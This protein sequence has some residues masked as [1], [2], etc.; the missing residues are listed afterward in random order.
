MIKHSR[1]LLAALAPLL[2][3]TACS[4]GGGTTPLSTVAS[5]AS[6][7]S[8]AMQQPFGLPNAAVSNAAGSKVSRIF[9]AQFQA[10][11]IELFGANG[12]LLGNSGSP[13][14]DGPQNIVFDKTGT[15]FVAA[16]GTDD[17]LSY[18]KALA[19]NSAVVHLT[20]S[21]VGL[22][23]G[24]TGT[25]F[26]TLYPSGDVVAY[27][28]NGQQVSPTIPGSGNV[29]YVAVDAKGKIYVT[30]SA[31]NTLKTYKPDGTP[32]TPTIKT[33]LNG[34]GPVVVDAAGKIYVANGGGSGSI[35]TYTP[36]GKP[37]KPTIAVRG[38]HGLAVAKNG[39]IYVTNSADMS[40][41]TFDPR[42]RP[43]TP[44]ITGLNTP[45]GIAVL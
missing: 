17:I 8:A 30:D 31:A 32:T 14:I 36:G 33:G 7:Q 45:T 16:F 1:A 37:T 25:L 10:F 9:V 23:V 26:A 28:Q 21:P 27:D 34:P 5:G 6:L 35:T 2:A 38:P 15:L 41:Q 22:A 4:G 20:S 40:V 39:D 12:K 44:T 43:I 3:M 19:P 24:P 13:Q 29:T 42:G 18:T 11:N